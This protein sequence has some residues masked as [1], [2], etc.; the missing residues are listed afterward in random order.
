LALAP[1]SIRRGYIKNQ[2]IFYIIMKRIKN[3]RDGY[4]LNSKYW[5]DYKSNLPPIDPRLEAVAI[6]MI[7]SD[8]TMYRKSKEA[9][10]KFEQGYLQE[11]FLL[12]LFETFKDY[13]WM[14]EPGKRYTLT[15]PRKGLVKSLW[16]KTFSHHSFTKIWDLFYVNGSKTIQKGLISDNLTVL[17]LAY[18][19]MG[20]GSLSK[21][22]IMTLHT[23]SYSQAE[24]LTLTKELNSLFGFNAKVTPHKDKYWVITFSAKDSRELIHLIKSYIIPSMAY[25]IG[26]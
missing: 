14:I 7:L 1:L 3:S 22:G 17:G 2:N 21:N 16:F 25:K 23:Q 8:A 9:L 5:Q 18:W 15:G 11:A 10:I 4:H 12:H 24:N 6:G 26:S 13:C 19:V 20:D